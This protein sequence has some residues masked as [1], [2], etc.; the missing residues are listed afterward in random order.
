MA[1]ARAGVE[2]TLGL[3]FGALLKIALAFTMMG[4]FALDRLL[5]VEAAIYN[6][7]KCV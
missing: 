5:R 4:V 2:A 1:A 7:F 6:G 3:L